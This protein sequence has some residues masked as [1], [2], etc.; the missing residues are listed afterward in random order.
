ML[1]FS[2]ATAIGSAASVQRGAIS[3]AS[4]APAPYQTQSRQRRIDISRIGTIRQR[5]Q[6]V[7]DFSGGELAP[8]HEG[9]ALAERGFECPIADCG[10]TRHAGAGDVALD[11]GE[12]E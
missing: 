10:A 9:E 6:P 2:T 11:G 8:M 12:F 1:A 5:H 7:G 3:A 4:A